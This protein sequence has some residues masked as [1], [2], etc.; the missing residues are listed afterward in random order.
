MVKRRLR[1][2]KITH[3]ERLIVKNLTNLG[4]VG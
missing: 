1:N 2:E 3:R 4:C